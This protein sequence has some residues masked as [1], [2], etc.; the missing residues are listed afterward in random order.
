MK[1]AYFGGDLFSCCMTRLLRS[2]HE[3]IQLFTIDDL[4]SQKV[5]ED[6]IRQGIPVTLSKPTAEHI[7]VLKQLGCEMI[8]SAGYSHKIPEWE[9]GS[10]RYGVNI[11]PSLLPE[12]AGPTP[13]PLA[14]T[15]G[16]SRT[17]VTLHKLSK[18][19]DS[20]DIILQRSIPLF[21][22]EVL[23]DLFRESQILSLELLEQFMS[24]PQR[25]WESAK[26]QI[27]KKSDYWP[28]R[29][30]EESFIDC[31]LDIQTV[32]K[33]LRA[34]LG[35]TASRELE[36]VTEVTDIFEHQNNHNL[37]LGISSLKKDGWKVATAIDGSICFKLAREKNL[38]VLATLAAK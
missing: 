8:L 33:R 29:P 32:Q 25:H 38:S 11:H 9:G 3:I 4:L 34:H 13:I 31:S 37:K 5:K 35:S 16:L 19:W 18:Q 20:G 15:K 22:D 27:R 26:P 10:I 2:D 28:S 1:I 24:N 7:E 17:G 12:G 36:F 23:I 14:I 30:K 21:G 6:A